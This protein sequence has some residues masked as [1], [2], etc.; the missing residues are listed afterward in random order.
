[1]KILIRFILILLICAGISF[2]QIDD[3]LKKVNKI[4]GVPD[5]TPGGAV[6]T[7]INDV[8]PVVPWLGN[9]EGLGDPQP[10]TDF[11][12]G[13]GYYR[14]EIQTYCLH[15]GTYGPTQGDGYLVAPLL[16][17]QADLISSILKRS[18]N[19]PG[20]AQH[21]IQQLIWGIEAGAKFTD[22][23]LDYQARVK[24]LLT[25]EEIAKL[26]VDLSPAFNVV[27]NE[28]K[29]A[30]NTYSD[31]RKRLV[32]PSSNYQD[33]ENIAVKT[34]IPPIGPGSKTVD[35]GNWTYMKDGFFIRTFPVAYPHSFI[36]IYRPSP[37]NVARDGKN[38]ITSFEDNGCKMDIVYNDDPGMDILSTSGNPDVPIWRIK[39]IVLHGDAGQQQSLDNYPGW[40]VKDKGLP[41]SGSNANSHLDGDPAYS[42]YQ[43]RVQ[44]ANQ[45]LIAF[46][47]YVKDRQK[48]LK[49]DGGNT[50]NMQSADGDDEWAN[51]QITNGL[52]VA[53]NGTN[54]SGQEKW[55]NQNVANTTNWFNC[56]S[57]ALA[58]GDCNPDKNPHKF[59]PTHHVSTP[60]N[61]NA[62]RLGMSIRQYG[63]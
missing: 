8:Y 62:Q 35:P 36:E 49:G 6:T 44:S 11:N 1:M 41:I 52:H 16:G 18:E 26:S 50:G 29:D 34:G 13:P 57:N 38:R 32:D 22:Y 58:G 7:S 43:D 25:T 39:S 23:P 45:F 20:I 2:A 51:T 56:A 3:I 17:N 37:V 61:T 31:M 33:V 15:A 14:T 42:E 60:G 53:L 19:F 12:L 24:P 46:E 30:A 63:Q 27:P 55:I 47:Q 9:M 59:D 10:V 21:D 54:K 5:W 40:I 48:Q 4:P 28:L